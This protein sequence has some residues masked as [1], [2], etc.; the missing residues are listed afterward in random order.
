MPAA[1]FNGTDSF[2]YKA[3]DGQL[4]SNVATVTIN[5]NPVNDAPVAA[6]DRYNTADGTALTVNTPTGVLTNDTDV[7]SAALTAALVA[8]P[9]NGTVTLNA[10]G[11]FQYVPNSGF[12]GADSFTYQANDGELL[13]NVATVTI[14]VND[15]PV[16]VDDS[17][18]LTVNPTTGGSLIV[19]A[20]A[21]LIRNDHDPDGDPITL[22]RI[23]SSSSGI[24]VSAV[25]NDGS[26]HVV[27][28][29]N[30]NVIGT[31]QW[32]TYTAVDSYGAVS[33][34]ATV[35]ITVVSSLG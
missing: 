24:Q 29:I 32:F 20:S 12:H 34:V 31:Q 21:G 16:A 28:G 11:S 3:N 9:G 33:N 8:G 5:I 2:T 23:I 13:S 19:P 1:N 17:Y 4:D 15:P 6:N 27:V 35:H 18:T 22:D 26:F 14:V 25:G 10:D 7:D 30:A